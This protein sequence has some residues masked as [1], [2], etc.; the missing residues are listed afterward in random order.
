M[1]KIMNKIKLKKNDIVKV[2]AGKSK[3]HVGK[4]TKVM[5]KDNKIIVEGANQVKKH[6]KASAS[7]PGTI[8][9]VEMP[10][11]ISKVAYYLSNEQ[12]CTKIGYKFDEN[13]KKI[14]FAKLTGEVI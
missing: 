6:F 14:R 12:K 2:T 7:G 5:P 9:S 13:N 8:K 11:D 1:V 4:I 3:G 10:L